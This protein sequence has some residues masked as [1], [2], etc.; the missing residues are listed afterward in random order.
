[1]PGLFIHT[2]DLH[3]TS[4]L[5]DVTL[6]S[7]FYYLSP[8]KFCALFSKTLQLITT[9]LPLS[10]S[11]SLP[12]SL[13]PSLALSLSRSL[14]LSLSRARSLSLSIFR[15]PPTLLPAPIRSIVPQKPG[16]TRL[17]SILESLVAFR[18]NI[19]DLFGNFCS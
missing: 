15:T 16:M 3:A 19:H 12:R 5:P 9:L 17:R 4:L 6:Y 10:L 11:R 18:A 2:H 14:A 13:P 1:M 8:A 7:L